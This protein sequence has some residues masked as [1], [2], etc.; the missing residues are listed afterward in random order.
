M[1]PNGELWTDPF[2]QYNRYES[3]VLRTVCPTPNNKYL[4]GGYFIN[5]QGYP[6]KRL[7][8][9]DEYGYLDTLSPLMNID[10]CYECDDFICVH[11]IVPIGNDRY[12]VAGKFAGYEGHEVEPI[13]R[14]YNADNSVK[15]IVTPEFEL[16]PNPA[17]EKI[18]LTLPAKSLFVTVHDITGSMIYSSQIEQGSIEYSINCK[19]WQNG[20][21]LCTI[22]TKKGVKVSSYFV[23]MK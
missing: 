10:T 6:A 13:I 15:E 16:F 17:S 5:Y 23:V 1:K 11:D 9:I 18:T 20:T 14:I 8:L 22:E 4:I 21:Y 2:T 19:A 3:Y 12:Y 7:A